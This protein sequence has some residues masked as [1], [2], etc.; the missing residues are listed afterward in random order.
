MLQRRTQLISPYARHPPLLF[1]PS[2]SG[3]IPSQLLVIYQEAALRIPERS[4]RPVTHC[5]WAPPTYKAQC[6]LPTRRRTKVHQPRRGRADGASH[7]ILA[8]RLAGSLGA[9]AMLTSGRGE[10][11][12]DGLLPVTLH[13]W[14]VPGD[15]APPC[16]SRP[17]L[18]GAGLPSRLPS[19]DF[20]SSGQ[21]IPAPR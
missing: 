3:P 21:L 18:A 10:R 15:A 8:G 17:I 16:S 1:H 14:R 12:V 19:F 5:R 13:W 2:P 4:R 9:M 20:T 11:R 7:Q 6:W